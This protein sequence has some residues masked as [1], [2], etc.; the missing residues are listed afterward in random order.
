VG[1]LLSSARYFFCF[2]SYEEIKRDLN[3]RFIHE[4][5]CDERLKAKAGGSTCLACTGLCGIGVF[6]PRDNHCCLLLS[7]KAR[8]K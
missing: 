3:R 8:V 7:D 1:R 4:Y 2:A 6:C 5:R